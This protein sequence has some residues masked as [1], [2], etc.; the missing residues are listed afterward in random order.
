MRTATLMMTA[1]WLLA[2]GMSTV[3]VAAD[4]DTVEITSL[5][6]KRFEARDSL[7]TGDEPSED[8]RKCLDGLCWEATEF[9]TTCEQPSRTGRGDIMIRFPSPVASGDV[10]NDR[11][12]MEWYV[13]RNENDQ[14]VEARAVVV[15]HE[16]GRS[17]TVGRTFAR[18][19]RL[20]GLHAFLLHLPFYGE[21]RTDG[22]RPD[23]SNLVTVM[24][25]AIADARRARDA[26]ASL[27]AGGYVPHCA[28]GHKS[29]GNCCGLRGGLGRRV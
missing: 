5:P 17:M 2:P 3:T 6:G 8:A 22:K 16:S 25:Q 27:T 10:R 12:A 23:D 1:T 21:R 11:V 24:R 19:L 13:A 26:V 28:A 9:V 7:D 14:P 29:R 4:P 20:Q 18:G 15:V